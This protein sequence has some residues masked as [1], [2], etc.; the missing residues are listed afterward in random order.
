M[1][2]STCNCTTTLFFE[3]A[4]QVLGLAVSMAVCMPDS[5]CDCMAFSV[6]LASAS[7]CVLPHK[8]FKV[9]TVMSFCVCV[10]PF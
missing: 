2:M 8:G 6:Y 3:G 7:A 4:V 1:S 5:C 9:Q 10:Q